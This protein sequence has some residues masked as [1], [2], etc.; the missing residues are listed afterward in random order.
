MNKLQKDQ[1]QDNSSNNSN[2]KYADGDHNNNLQQPPPICC[3]W[4]HYYYL[5]PIIGIDFDTIQQAI[6][7]STYIVQCDIELIQQMDYEQEIYEHRRLLQQQMIK[8]QNNLKHDQQQQDKNDIINMNVGDNNDTNDQIIHKTSNNDSVSMLKN[9]NYHHDIGLYVNSITKTRK[10]TNN[11]KHIYSIRILC[12]PEIIH[13]ISNSIVVPINDYIT[14]LTIETRLPK[15]KQTSIGRMVDNDQQQQSHH[16]DY[17]CATNIAASDTS[18]NDNIMKQNNNSK[19]A[20]IKSCSSTKEHRIRLKNEP[21]FHLLYGT[22]KLCN[23]S[24]HHEC[25]GIDIWNGNSAIYIG[26]SLVYELSGTPMTYTSLEL[27]TVDIISTTGR[28]I[29]GM[30]FVCFFHFY[31]FLLHLTI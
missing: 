30:F 13:Y 4:K 22:L 26:S 29:V 28:G 6:S 23:V 9:D 7:Y 18:G 20:I 24:L 19:M 10:K 15:N 3:L 5:N 14:S 2:I 21:L 8:P 12:Q 25:I 16:T 1:Q 17:P 11:K 31:V 27:D